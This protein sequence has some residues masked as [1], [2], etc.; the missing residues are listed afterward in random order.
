MR[1]HQDCIPCF[2]RQAL[3]AARLATDAPRLHEAILREA[4][5]HVAR[6]SWASPPPCIA[7]DLHRRIRA[8]LQDDDPFREV[9]ARTNRLA[10]EVL[11]AL[12]ERV[13][14]AA[15]PLETAVRVAIAG[16]MIDFSTTGS[17]VGLDLAAKT[18]AVLARPLAIDHLARLAER[19]ASAERIMVLGDNAGEIVFDRLLVEVLGPARV[20]YVVRGGPIIND[21]TLDDARSTGLTDLVEVVP[22]G[23]DVPG[24]VLDEV[25]E[26]V[27]RRF[28]EADL[29]IAKG[30]GNYET[31]DEETRPGLL[32]LLMVKCPSL[33]S[34]LG[35]ELGDLVVKEAGVAHRRGA[36]GAFRR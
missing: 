21:A 12:A 26:D 8:I 19:L 31:L 18:D 2:L 33:A 5:A 16:N 25:S 23:S 30:Q 20:T 27:R 3:S 13:H 14:A 10:L 15:D 29:V 36:G 6:V 4:A 7:R 34:G 1:A 17:E 32:F 11:P 22:S 35:C 24:T 28:R 9:K